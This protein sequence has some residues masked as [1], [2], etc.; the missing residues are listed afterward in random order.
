MVRSALLLIPVLFAAMLSDPEG[1]RAAPFHSPRGYHL[2]LPD[3]WKQV[4]EAH[5]K[6]MAAVAAGADAP[7]TAVFDAAFQ[8]A[9]HARPFEYPY[10]VVQVI[11]YGN[12]GLRSPVEQDMFESVTRA[13]VGRSGIVGSYADASHQAGSPSLIPQVGTPYVS[14]AYRRFT[15]NTEAFITG[16]GKISGVVTGYFGAEEVVV[17]CYYAPA[18][19]LNQ[20]A[21]EK[22][23]ESLT[24][25]PPKEVA[26]AT[27]S[28]SGNSIAD[29][30]MEGA[31]KGGLFG[32]AIALIH[33]VRVLRRMP[34][35]DD[36]SPPPSR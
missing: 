27:H 13:V 17:V 20:A 11:R 19:K 1:A 30:A 2:N 14:T 10:V 36:K 7:K 32:G 24:F 35:E 22:I 25:D 6:A 18:G 26:P 28:E 34:P 4:P 33:A 3:D 23:T 5:L 12:L 15:V 21:A 9:S 29:R 31:I 8:P 16:R